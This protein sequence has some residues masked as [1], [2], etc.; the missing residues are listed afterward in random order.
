VLLW[1]GSAYGVWA[2]TKEHGFYGATILLAITLV[3]VGLVT[4]WAT[5]RALLPGAGVIVYL[6]RAVALIVATWRTRAAAP[7][8]LPALTL[9]TSRSTRWAT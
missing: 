1:C 5:D 7:G 3:L 8:L 9:A 4:P 2:S 6:L